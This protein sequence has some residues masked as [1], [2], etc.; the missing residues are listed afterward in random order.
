MQADMSAG[1]QIYKLEEKD[2]Q[3]R[4]A[5]YDVLEESDINS[6]VSLEEQ[7]KNKEEF[8]NS[9][10]HEKKTAYNSTLPKTGRT[11]LQK[12]FGSK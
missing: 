2:N 5:L 4:F 7:K 6:V 8:Y 11:W 9:M 3:G 12:L 1:T 10:K